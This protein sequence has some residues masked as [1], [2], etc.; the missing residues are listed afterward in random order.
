MS[1]TILL[2]T[3]VDSTLSPPQEHVH[4][5]LAKVAANAQV[6]LPSM[7]S[8]GILPL[9]P[10][11]LA[12]LNREGSVSDGPKGA[13]V[14]MDKLQGIRST[15]KS[16]TTTAESALPAP[17]VSCEEPSKVL[18]KSSSSLSITSLSSSLS[19]SSAAAPASSASI[20]SEEVDGSLR[21]SK[22]VL[23]LQERLAK[24]RA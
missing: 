8:S 1:T 12:N 14:L 4:K 5:N 21:A 17:T 7:S 22:S 13:L 18:S 15:Y 23:S 9:Q 19:A 6:G 20:E 11:S 16:T 24:L 3:S 10:S 2:S